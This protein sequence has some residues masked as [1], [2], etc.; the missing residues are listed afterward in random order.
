MF[1]ENP[2]L[3][4]EYGDGSTLKIKK[5]F[6]TIQGEGPY[7]GYP[8][9]FIRLSGCNLACTF[10]DTDFDDYEEMFVN[11]IMNV[12]EKYWGSDTTNYNTNNNIDNNITNHN[13]KLIVI[14]G[15]EPFRQNITLL[16]ET[17]IKNKYTVQIETNG[18]LYRKIPKEVK[19]VCSPKNNGSGYYKIHENI[20]RNTIAIKFL[21][22]SR[23]KNYSTISDVGQSEFNIPFYVQP[24]DEYNEEIN[25]ENINIAKQISMKHGAILSL[26]IHKILN[27]E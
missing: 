24:M 19:I 18:T 13:T 4:P 17:L 22:S 25:I 5:I 26:Q 27:I 15:G 6:F 9:V 11:D 1:G 7:S 16:C 14:T 3:P 8:A 23:N 10:C 2:I 20:L 21:I 12:L